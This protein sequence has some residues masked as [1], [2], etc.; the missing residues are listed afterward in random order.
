VPA[1]FNENGNKE[2]VSHSIFATIAASSN[3][4]TN[5]NEQSSKS[6][7]ENNNNSELISQYLP[8]QYRQGNLFQPMNPS[9]FKPA[10]N[11]TI[12]SKLITEPMPSTYSSAY[13]YY[14]RPYPTGNTSDFL[15][16]KFQPLLQKIL[17]LLK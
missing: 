12:Q 3:Q 5:L 1:T 4:S 9:S 11:Q 6:H 10:T 15:Y 7:S 14:T 8:N 17:P 13:N 16:K 2:K